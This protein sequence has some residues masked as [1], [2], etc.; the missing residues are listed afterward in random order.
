MTIPRRLDVLTDHQRAVGGAFLAARAAERHH[1]VVYLSGAHAYGFPSPDSDLDLKAVHIAPTGDLVGLVPHPGGAER[2]EIVD[3]V[4]LDYSSNELGDV[5]QGV[6][7]GNGN[8]LERLLGDLV[9]AADDVRLAELRPL[10]RAA[11][12][13][14]VVRHYGGFATSQRLAAAATPTAKKVLYVLRTARTGLHLLRTGELVTDL[15]ALA[16]IYGPPIEE[17]LAR[18]RT[19]ERSALDGGELARWQA[20]MSAAQ[21][22]LD[23]AVGSSVLPAEPPPA[24]VRALDDWLR[25]TRKACW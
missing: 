17:L 1:L 19:G 21:A 2:L 8:Y 3:G 11:L 12:S 23:G 6:L 22:D 25:A 14:R 13:R 9:L 24:V 15:T 4:E 10:A 7:K 5:L 16:P 20:A 18:K